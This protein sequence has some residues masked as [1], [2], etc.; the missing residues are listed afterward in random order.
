M[1]I[2]LTDERK[3]RVLT[4]I[5][6]YFAE[7]FDEELRDFRAEQPL[8]FFLRELGPPVYNQVLS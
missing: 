4:S 6:K 3:N 8:D 7:V 5:K 2:K 1:R